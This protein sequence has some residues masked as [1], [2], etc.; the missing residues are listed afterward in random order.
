M[1]T[2]VTK[3]FPLSTSVCFEG[4]KDKI[5]G[6]PE[7]LVTMESVFNGIKTSETIKALTDKIRKYKEQDNEPAKTRTKRKLPSFVVAAIFNSDRRLLADIKDFTGLMV[8]DFD[9]VD[10]IKFK[11]QLSKLPII[12]AAFVSPSGDGVKVIVKTPAVKDRD[13]HVGTF[14]S[15][16]EYFNSEHF[17]DSGKDYTRLCYMS[18]DPDIYINENSTPWTQQV[19]QKTGS[20]KVSPP[21]PSVD[22]EQR[23]EVILTEL[24]KIA[25]WLFE[26]ITTNRNNTT[27]KAAAMFCDYGISQEV[28]LSIMQKNIEDWKDFSENEFKKAT[29]QGYKQ[30][31]AGSKTV[32]KRPDIPSSFSRGT[33][34]PTVIAEPPAETPRSSTSFSRGSKR[35]AVPEPPTRIVD[36]LKQHVIP[37][38]EPVIN[39]SSS[40]SRGKPLDAKP[41]KAEVE[42][43]TSRSKRESIA[44]ELNDPVFWYYKESGK[45]E[46]KKRTMT[47]DVVDLLDWLGYFGYGS[48][49]ISEET[50]LVRMVDNVV[51]TVTC[52]DI[53]H[54][55]I[56]W[57]DDLYDFNQRRGDEAEVKRMFL[58]KPALTE[59]KNLS[60]LPPIFIKKLRDKKTSSKL[61]YDNAVV[62]ITQRTI[63]RSEYKDLEAPIWK[64]ELNGRIL[65]EQAPK[66]VG[67][68]EQFIANV[69]DL[70]EDTAEH[71]KLA[72][73]TAIGYMIHGYKNSKTSKIITTNDSHISIEGASSGRSGK[74]IFGKSFGNIRSR[75]EVSGKT[76]KPDDKFW[77]QGVRPH[78][79]IV[80]FEDMPRK[81]NW[82]S[83]YNL[84]TDDWTTEQKYQGSTQISAEDSPKMI[85]S[86]NFT[87]SALDPST[88]DRIHNL[89]F[90]DH[91]HAGVRGREDY[92]PCDDFGCDLFRDWTGENAIQWQY[93][94]HYMIKC[95]QQYFKHGLIAAKTKNL[96]RRQLI[97]AVGMS[98]VEWIEDAIESKVILF[99]VKT[100]NIAVHEQYVR[101]CHDNNIERYDRDQRSFTSKMYRYFRDSGWDL[102]TGDNIKVAHGRGRVRGFIV[103]MTKAVEQEITADEFPPEPDC[104]F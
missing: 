14:L 94:D 33:K 100:A 57:L 98:L 47:I 24:R 34:R 36:G 72:F 10:V 32:T 96:Q 68:F 81:F 9:H 67:H 50:V 1:Q 61:Y 17:D 5:G 8:I 48:T 62:T 44:D 93:Y 4:T 70:G 77:L 53:K 95:L 39:N 40:F 37:D 91:Y 41:E 45:G 79:Q 60:G 88:I 2:K 78:H 99:D 102:Q 23:E 86:T 65:E 64:N 7:K 92:R 74:G 80:N 52:W 26:P 73:E 46:D 84:A 54:F 66:G 103:S 104:P 82:E 12:F 3:C 69:S 25:P 29:A 28:A 19:T 6:H 97:N 49:K 89:E 101:W 16:K 55:I 63:K 11:E 27:M 15:L 85:A 42:T 71:N 21:R 83:L 38:A 22:V 20:S 90:S 56:N 18:H 58:S 87:V 43:K 51:E 30:G 13:S 59:L 31:D 75:Y 76:L 35:E